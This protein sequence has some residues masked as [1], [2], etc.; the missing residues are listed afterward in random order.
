[1]PP[2]PSLPARTPVR[3]RA[4]DDDGVS[5]TEVLVVCSVMIIVVLGVLST[6]DSAAQ[7]VPRDVER[8]HAIAEGRVGVLRMVRE[9]RGA[10]TIRGTTPN[11]VDFETSVGGVVRRVRFAC[12]VPDDA[13]QGFRRCTRVEAVAGAELPAP[14]AGATLVSRVRNGTAADPVFTGVPDGVAPRYLRVRVLVP[15]TGERTAHERPGHDVVLE[16]GAY[17]RNRD[18]G[19]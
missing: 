2:P 1:M 11:S 18:L 19:G 14:T 13:L 3:P 17:L 16:D 10:E 15:S 8:T 4:L 6:L 5:L 7:T 9:L 12:E